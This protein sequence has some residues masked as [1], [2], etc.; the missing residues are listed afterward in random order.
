VYA[1]E[2]GSL[3]FRSAT[4]VW[5][6]RVAKGGDRLGYRF[7]QEGAWQDVSWKQA[8]EQAREIAAGLISIGIRQGDRVC[9]LAQTRLEWLLVDLG[10]SMAGAA[11][12][13][14]YSSSTAEQAAYVLRDSGARAAVV[15]DAAQ[16]EKLLP[17]LL[18]GADLHLVYM[19]AGEARLDRPDARG[20]KSVGMGDVMTAVPREA[21]RRIR[22]LEDL[23]GA[24]RAW[25]AKG[26]NAAELE[27][28]R[29]APGPADTFT[30]IYTSGTT[31]N[32]KG[33]VLSHENIVAGCA[34]CCRAFA[35]REG[36]LHYV[37]L[38]LAHVLA[39]E[40]VWASL[41]AG[42]PVVFSEGLAKIKDNLGEVRPTFMAGVPRIYEKFHAGL[43]ANLKQTSGLKGALVSWALGVGERHSA[44]LREGK[45]PAAP[46]SIGGWLGF[47]HRWADRLVL[48]KLRA[49]LGLDR[50]RF[51]ISGGAPL[52]ADIAA[53]FHGV[54]ILI[55]E[56]YGLT[57]TTA[58]AFVNRPDRYRFGTVGPAIDVIESRVAED[59]EI[60]MRG[61]SVFKRYHGDPAATAEAIDADGW[62]HSGDIGQIE[63]GY[64]RITDRKKDLIVLAGGKKVAPQMLE[65]AL[66]T[67][68]SLLSQA[69]VVGDR[70]PYVV[71]LLTLTDEAVK[72]YGG[73]AARA[74]GHAEVKAAMKQAVDGVNGT[75]ASFETIKRYSILP[76][77]FTEQNGQLTPSL[78]VK[79][80][81]AIDRHRAVIE[82][83]YSGKE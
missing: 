80:K 44:K 74:A 1:V 43:Q 83:L 15:E 75:L 32:P 55:L 48:S 37:W 28:R 69:L 19:D 29:T 34:S 13:P 31:G 24:G 66:K 77:D 4:E 82:A 12:V 42:I 14:I 49:R 54:G 30:I 78:K 39:R 6:D 17:Q 76:D 51:L 10:V 20:R 36:D 58:A 63:D 70:K 65:N 16:L 57:E 53:F 45:V 52:A 61:P 8:D 2:P 9:V 47:Q 40:I 62:F 21:A 3:P 72:H 46:G 79:R 7:K 22:S 35:L 18:T 5:A 38:T 56:G 59:G 27:R 11:S 23:R 68:S 64:L 41:Y 73:D 60:L 67:R 26:Q 71:A 33:V 81:I 25:L 50:C